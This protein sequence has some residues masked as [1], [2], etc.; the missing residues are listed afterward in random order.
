MSINLLQYRTMPPAF[1]V[2]MFTN[3]WDDIP[4]YSSRH[5]PGMEG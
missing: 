2:I 3:V 4:Q 5:F 1:I